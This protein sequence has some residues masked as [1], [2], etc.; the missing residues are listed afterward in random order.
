M[1]ND[2]IIE[3]VK[4]I[5]KGADDHNW[6]LIENAMADKVLLD[7]FSLSGNPAATISAKQ[8]IEGWKGFLPK[9]ERTHHQLSDFSVDSQGN[10]A[11]VS[12]KGKADH[13]INKDV[14]TVEGT[15]HA[16]VVNRNNSWKVTQLKF[17]LSKQSGNLDSMLSL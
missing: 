10:I 3:T 5:F 17:I 14:W 4:S 12:F 11:N 2:I 9:F 6:Q 8:I 16:E 1:E 15:Y 7:Y 13:F